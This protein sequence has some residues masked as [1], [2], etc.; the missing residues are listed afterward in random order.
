M[1]TFFLQQHAK[2][3]EVRHIPG[4]GNGNSGN[5]AQDSPQQSGCLL[6]LLPMHNAATAQL[7]Y[8]YSGPKNT[9]NFG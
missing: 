4:S 2:I 7:L 6:F 5:R 3:F 9:Q 8:T 1:G